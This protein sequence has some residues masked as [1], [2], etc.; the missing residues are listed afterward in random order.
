MSSAID[1]M[2]AERRQRDA[3]MRSA[4]AEIYKDFTGHE[5][6]IEV[7]VGEMPFGKPFY[8]F[9][10]T[11]EW[12]DQN[13]MLV[14]QLEMF[15][16]EAGE[17]KRIG[18]EA[19]NIE[20]T[21]ENIDLI[22]QRSVNFSRATHI[23]KYLLL[24]PFHNLPDLVLVVTEPWVEHPDAPEWVDG[25][26]TRDS[27]AIDPISG[28]IDKALLRLGRSGQA[29]R[30]TMYA[31]DGQHRLIGI[32]AAI[33]MLDKGALTLQKEDGTYVSGKSNVVNVGI[34]TAPLVA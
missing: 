3:D 12:I 11:T 2:I 33:A 16:R 5:G 6:T 30:S 19:G 25:R 28:D 7:T 9:Q 18:N 21:S 22:R 31:L 26:A 23:A 29:D 1:K 4:Y 8:T 10:T 17:Y 27:V 15:N 32:R 24:H 13:V 14:G 34:V 20:I